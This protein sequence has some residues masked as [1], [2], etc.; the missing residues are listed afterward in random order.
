M[1]NSILEITIPNGKK[2]FCINEEEVEF[3]Y[4][5]MPNYIKHG[6]KLNQ[7]DTIF[8]VGANIGMFSLMCSAYCNDRVHIYAFEPIPQIFEV[9]QLNVERFS[10]DRVKLHNCGLSN[11]SKVVDFEYYPKASGFS[12]MFPDDP[13]AFRK[14]VSSIMLQNTEELPS[15]IREDIS[16]IPS[17]L[18][19]LFLDFK[20]RNALKSQTVNARLKTISQ[21]IQEQNIQQIDLLKIDV[22]KSELDVLLGIQPEHWIKIKQIVIEAHDVENRVNKIENLLLKHGFNNTTI[23]QEPLLKKSEY[24]NIYATRG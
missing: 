12:T 10:L 3:L 18:R 1:S 23:E 15:S 2:V 16:K 14:S 8:D 4:S 11:T 20:L 19:S 13:P 7:E 5:Q 21:I 24:F 22:E 17:F 6:I 9:L